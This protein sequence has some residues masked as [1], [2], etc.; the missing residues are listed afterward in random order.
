M[1]TTQTIRNLQFGSNEPGAV[2]DFG[3]RLS[4]NLA[5]SVPSSDLNQLVN[6]LKQ[7]QQFGQQQVSSGQLEQTQR[8][9]APLPQD[10]AQVKLSP[11]QILG[12]RRGEVSAVE[13]TIGGARR[14]VQETES[15]AGNIQRLLDNFRQT[16]EQLK[17]DVR[18][19]IALAAQGGSAGLESLVKFNPDAFKTAGLD[20][21]SYI[22]AIKA[23]E[24]EEKRRF[25]VK[26]QP[27]IKPLSGEASKIYSIAT[28]MIPEIQQLKQAFKT[29]YKSSVS[30]IVSK[31]DR[32]LV[33]LV[34]QVADKV[35]RLRSG[36]AVNKDEEARFKRQIASFGDILFGR[37]E[38][39]IRALDALIGEAQ[40]VAQGIRPQHQGETIIKGGRRFEIIP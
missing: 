36:G 27:E 40:S 13:P 35:G 9:T 15:A 31:T 39:A 20:A 19:S 25:E 5:Q 3:R 28:S 24:A 7:Y 8:A 32:R 26:Q 38:D 30:G 14:L 29:N 6:L 12:F 1:A 23:K 16:Q 10:L 18:Q 11:Q 37:P 17:N 33:K 4:S 21:E 22:A 34:D 2:L